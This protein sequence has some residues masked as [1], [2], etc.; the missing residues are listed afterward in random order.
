MW[1]TGTAWL[2]ELCVGLAWDLNGTPSGACELNHYATRPAS[3]K[4]F[5]RWTVPSL[6][7]ATGQG[8]HPGAREEGASQGDTQGLV[9]GG[10]KSWGGG[11]G[12]FL[13]KVFLEKL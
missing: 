11:G 12:P 4:G 2:N 7:R 8:G 10:G 1:D 13:W 9:S 5:L 3:Q 6:Q